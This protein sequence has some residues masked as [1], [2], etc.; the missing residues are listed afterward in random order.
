MTQT[1]RKYSPIIPAD[2][3]DR[4]TA[5]GLALDDR[6]SEYTVTRGG[7][8]V[9]VIWGPAVEGDWFL[10]LSGG[11]ER[12]TTRDGALTK[13]TE[14]VEL[15]NRKPDDDGRTWWACSATNPVMFFYEAPNMRAALAEFRRDL[16]AGMRQAGI[17]FRDIRKNLAGADIRAV[18]GPLTTPAAYDLDTAQTLT[19]AT[20]A[21]RRVPTG[22][23]AQLAEMTA[24]LTSE[25]GEQA[26]KI[27]AG[28]L[29]RYEAKDPQ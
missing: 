15:A 12:I 23:P 21:P 16:T 11:V 8:T 4:M 18:A 22:S 9:A 25:L 6:D 7:G 28:V 14:L 2:L 19:K 24:T 3:T 26:T 20:A 1:V 27:R 17:S 10:K 5:A 29:A 13:V